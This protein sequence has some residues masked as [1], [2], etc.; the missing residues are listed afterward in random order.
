MNI[1]GRLIFASPRV[2]VCWYCLSL[3]DFVP[4]IG[5]KRSELRVYNNK[6]GTIGVW[7]INESCGNNVRIE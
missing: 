6:P 7:E 5:P 2:S 4:W 1:T 3:F